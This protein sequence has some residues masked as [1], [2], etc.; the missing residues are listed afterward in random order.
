MAYAALKRRS[1]IV[2]PAS[3]SFSATCETRALPM[4][5]EFLRRFEP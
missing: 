5:N 2:V 3:A 1:S 4:L